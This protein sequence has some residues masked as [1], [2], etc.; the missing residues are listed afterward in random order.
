MTIERTQSTQQPQHV[1]EDSSQQSSEVRITEGAPLLPAPDFSGGDTVAAIAKLFVKSA[2]HKRASQDLSAQAEEVA[3]D[4]ADARRLDAMKVKAEDTLAAGIAGG[5]SQI[6]SGAGSI[7][8]GVKGSVALGAGVSPDVARN[9]SSTW[10]GSG[11]A[12]GGMLKLVE[13][14]YRSGADGAEQE[15]AKAE[16]QGKT[17]KRAQDE[18]RRQVDAASQHEAKVMQLLQEIKQAQAQCERAALLRM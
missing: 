15:M 8:G 7:V 14:G 11:A 18:L 17:A 10:D 6:A 13:A 5:A 9:T 16:A 3:E 2:E 1:M 12:S 4:A